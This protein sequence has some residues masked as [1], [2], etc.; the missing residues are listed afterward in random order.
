[1]ANEITI[2]DTGLV[3]ENP[4]VAG[5]RIH[6]QQPSL[7]ML[8]AKEFVATFILDHIDKEFSG[9]VVVSRSMDAGNTWD[10]EGNVIDGPP[11]STT[12]SMPASMLSDG[13]L[14]GVVQMN[15][16]DENH[17]SSVNVETYGRVPGKLYIVRSYDG[18]HHWTKP[19]LLEP[20]LAG[21]GWEVCH[22]VLELANGRLLIPTAT[23]RGWDGESPSG[24][25]T[26]AF[27]SDD[28]GRTWPRHSIIF[29]GRDTLL[30]HWEK[31]VIQLSDGGILAVAWVYD[32]S[33]NQTFPSVYTTSNNNGESFS[34]PIKIGF[35]A[36]TCKIIQIRDGR[37]LAIYRRHDQPGL[38]ATVARINGG[39]WT[40]LSSSLV[41]Q[42]AESGMSGERSGAEELQDLKFGY[43]NS[44]Q[45]PNG[46]I[47]VLFWCQEEGATNIRWTRL[48]IMD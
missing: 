9:R 19:S 45:L 26:V 31:S 11:P 40:N 1:M 33:T 47:L 38:W 25:Q 5:D 16:F 48:R 23:W 12:H 39:H 34:R 10:I 3:Y 37:I 17:P 32:T 8:T 6:V 14:I 21:P 2:V 44:A 22:H 42:G 41:W 35:L 20:P 27:I 30:T 15:Y 18:G 28:G 4:R 29:D 43:P 46:D 7:I 36:Q 24:E 13:S